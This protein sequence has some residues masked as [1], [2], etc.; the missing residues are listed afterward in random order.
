M[1]FLVNIFTCNRPLL[2]NRLLEDLWRHQG[3]HSV[4]VTVHCHSTE[5]PG[6]DEVQRRLAE[7]GSYTWINHRTA[8]SF[9]E[10]VDGALRALRTHD[11]DYVVFLPDDVRTCELFFD[12][13]LER[14]FDCEAD[15]CSSPVAGLNLLCETKRDTVPNWTKITPVRRG[16]V[17]FTGWVDGAFMT[18]PKAL[19]KVGWRLPGK[20]RR[21]WERFSVAFVR[22]GWSLYRS[23]ESLLCHV[24]TPSVMHQTERRRNP[25]FTA[26]FID[27][28]KARRSLSV[29]HPVHIG[30]ATTKTRLP[31]ARRALV[32]LE[33]Q[34]DVHVHVND[35]C[36]DLGDAGKFVSLLRS[37]C[38]ER[39]YWLTVDDDIIYTEDYVERMVQSIELYG[40]KAAISWHGSVIPTDGR[41]KSYF[42]NRRLV[43][44]CLHG[45][46]QDRF[47]HI[48]GT[49]VLGFYRPSIDISERTF[50]NGYMADIWFSVACNQQRVPRVAVRHQRGELQSIDVGER[51]LYERYRNND[52][53]HCRVLAEEAPWPLLEA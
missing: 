20:G 27:G 4:H 43:S 22:M 24:H 52:S 13:A 12:R 23:H 39:V 7:I 30:M 50:G 25:D 41:M 45:A 29:Q 53:V 51:T 9:P 36:S 21:A 16:A 33:G 3:E 2:C 26:R 32:S 15:S 42:R 28:V 18:R 38:D 34:A 1:K 37:V 44:H 5:C 10:M 14:W 17:T 6:Y 49:G 35:R 11:V 19:S 31:A 47:V 40:R 48:V 8:T 46:I